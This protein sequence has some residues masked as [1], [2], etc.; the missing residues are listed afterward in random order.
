MAC[1]CAERRKQL[2][3]SLVKLRTGD[4]RAAGRVLLD[5]AVSTGE[6]AVSVVRGFIEEVRAARP[7]ETR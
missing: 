6:D 3:A 1:R 4:A 7:D 2:S 5:V